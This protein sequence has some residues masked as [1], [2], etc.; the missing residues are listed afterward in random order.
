MYHP[1][2]TPAD[3]QRCANDTNCD[4]HEDGNEMKSLTL[5]MCTTLAIAS[6]GCSS[7]PE[8]L[9]EGGYDEAEMAAAT[10]RAIDEVDAFIGELNAGRSESHAVKAPIEDAGET[11]H[12]WL[13]GVTFADN[14]FTGTIDNEP[15]MV[16]NVT[17]GQE[18]TL[19]K[20][21]ISDWMYMRD[22]K[23]YGNYTMRPL[24]ASM[25]EAEAERFRS[26]FANP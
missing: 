24:L 3:Q 7:K 11:E 4:L 18:Y 10:Q 16:S 25:P 19:G 15:G 2:A 23:L 21:E 9:I 26:M 13:T 14:K 20:T 6:V 22:G 8:T 17:L 5:L 1:L 12:F